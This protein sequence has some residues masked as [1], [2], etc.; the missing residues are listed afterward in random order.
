MKIGEPKIDRRDL[1]ASGGKKEATS[2]FT[3]RA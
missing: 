3:G 2:S 1:A